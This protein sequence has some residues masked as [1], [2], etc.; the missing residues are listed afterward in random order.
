MGSGGAMAA[1]G[2]SVLRVFL[3]ARTSSSKL[4][5][6]RREAVIKLRI[7]HTTFGTEGRTGLVAP[8]IPSH[9]RP[10]AIARID[11]DKSGPFGGFQ[12]TETY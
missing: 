6:T 5:L 3:K 11:F 10:W 1:T 7:S 4:L 12:M 9:G 8:Q 2:A